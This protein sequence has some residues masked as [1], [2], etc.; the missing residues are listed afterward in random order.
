MG[1][2]SVSFSD[3]DFVNEGNVY[4]E[5]G[6]DVVGLGCS[7][8]LNTQDCKG[9]AIGYTQ[10]G[11]WVEYSVTSVIA[12]KLVF[13]ANAATGLEGGSFVLFIDGKAVTDTVKVPQGEDW[14]TYAFVDG[15]TSEIAKGD[16]VLRIQFTGSYVNLDWIKFALTPEELTGVRNL[17]YNV[18]L[19]PKMDQTL[20]VF[21]ANGKFMGRI[22]RTS[23]SMNLAETLRQAGYA[24]GVYMVRG[25]G[26]NLRV[27]V[28]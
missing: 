8:T 16:H 11:E 10:T 27:L 23:T 3:K 14:N 15:E 20:K 1:G 22:D 6:V 25:T 7:D 26:A 5:D 2:Q 4:R 21:A 17:T 12:S 9:Y 18:N 13:R 24:K 28:K 19:M